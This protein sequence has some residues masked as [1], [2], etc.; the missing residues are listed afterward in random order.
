[1]KLVFIYGSPAVGKLTVAREIAK[2]TNL[3]VFHNHLTI[4][5]VTPVFEFGTVPF[6][7]VVNQF[8]LK[9][10][11]EA[12][13]MKVSLIFTFC[14]CKGSDD[15]YVSE[16]TNAVESN[17]GKICF[18]L[19]TAEKSEIEKRILSESRKSYSKLKDVKLLNEGW[20]KYDLFS[21]VPFGKSLILD[22]T[23]LSAE[24]AAKQIVEHFDLQ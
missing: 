6:W 7:K 16:V 19:L 10:L 12:A 13:R 5:A 15:A 17:G 11:G 2:Q 22:N 14:Y 8:R 18:V 21:P 3:K 4:D 23:N 9:I 20:E 1:M 24:N